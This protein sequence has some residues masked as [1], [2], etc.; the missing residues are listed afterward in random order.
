MASLTLVA[1]LGWCSVW[2]SFLGGL[3]DLLDY[4]DFFL[5][6]LVSLVIMGLKIYSY[7]FIP[8]ERKLS[9]KV[10]ISVNPA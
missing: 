8:F 2:A 6:D 9:Y 10:I 5:F 7:L 1:W 3:T 4:F